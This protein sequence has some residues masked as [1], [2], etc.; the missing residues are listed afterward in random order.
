MCV[1]FYCS[2]IVLHKFFHAM[3]FEL[4]KIFLS[5]QTK[6]FFKF[7]LFDKQL[8]ETFETNTVYSERKQICLTIHCI[9]V[10]FVL[11]DMLYS[12]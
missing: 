12:N 1:R 5:S 8:S 11:T 6:D 9:N 7:V 4:L 10:A 2:A 3:R